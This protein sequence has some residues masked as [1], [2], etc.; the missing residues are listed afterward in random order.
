MAL[1]AV[2]NTTTWTS[3]EV[4]T[5][6]DSFIKLGNHGSVYLVFALLISAF[7]VFR[8]YTKPV[9][10]WPVLNPTG[11]EIMGFKRRV[12]FA[13]IAGKLLE[14]GRQMFPEQ[15]YHMITDTCNLLILPPKFV[16]GIR[17][18]PDLNFSESITE[19]FHAYLPGF[20]TFAPGREDDLSKIVVKKQLTKMLNQITEPLSVETDFAIRNY[21]GTSTDWTEF[22]FYDGILD[23]V[24]R[25]SSRVFL[26]PELCRNQEWL[27]ITKNY[28]VDSFIAAFILR[29]F[30]KPL[31]WIIHWFLPQ[32]KR[33]RG[34]IADSKKLIESVYRSRRE[35]RQRMREEGGNV[36][37]FN[38]A[39]DWF[40]QE[41]KGEPYKEAYC[42]L[43][44]SMAAIH[45]T[46]DL[47][48][49][50]MVQIMLHPELFVAL[51]DEISK[52][53]GADGWKKT[54]LYNLKLLDSVLKESQ[55]LR[56]GGIVS[57]QRIALRDTRLPDGSFLPKGQRC[58]VDLNG[59][60]GM[61]S[62]EH[63]DNPQTFDPYRFTRMR[64]QPGL[65]S[66]SHLVSTGPSHLGFGHGQH[67]C[68]GRFFASNEVKVA[69]C[70]LLMNYNW[71]LPEGVVPNTMK[72]GFSM[73]TDPKLKILIQRRSE[74]E[75]DLLNL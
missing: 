28:T 73:A 50:T 31:R 5:Q 51:R 8:G 61:M 12:E 48:T 37:D 36:P 22:D 7:V 40:D 62:S 70:H 25:I 38:D 16:E 30:P 20:E 57:M 59:P 60:G 11:F 33:I 39:I 1:H 34:Q 66:K 68:P 2:D 23:I 6:K 10:K 24:A 4:W 32:C 14:K 41:A 54:S 27:D 71:K 63:Y 42:Q 15:P 47:L 65:D 29:L 67:S 49:E 26:G 52:V 58:A 53:L 18:N 45:T 35:L 17:N 9:D 64:G 44:L 55:R 56:P 13:D 21:F 3:S 46:T 75:I 72:S 74:P 19:E 69:L 43:G